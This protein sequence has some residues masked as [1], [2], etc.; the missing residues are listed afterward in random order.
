MALDTQSSN[1][2]ICWIPAEKT[3]LRVVEVNA[4]I[5]EFKRLDAM[6]VIMDMKPI[7]V[8]ADEGGFSRT[9]RNSHEHSSR[10]MSASILVC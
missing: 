7:H 4:Q 1:I 3:D 2:D 8:P 10:G 5:F 9:K 6:H